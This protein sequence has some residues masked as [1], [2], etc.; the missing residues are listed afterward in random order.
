MPPTET[1]RTWKWRVPFVDWTVIGFGAVALL[2]KS[3]ITTDQSAPWGSPVSKNVVLSVFD[4]EE[5]D[6][7]IVVV[8][9]V[10][11]EV[12]GA[13]VDVV[14]VDVD[15]VEVVDR[16]VDVVGCAKAADTLLPAGTFPVDGDG[17]YVDP[18][19]ETVG[20]S[21]VRVPAVDCIVMLF[22]AVPAK[23]TPAID[24]LHWAP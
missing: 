6:G 16:D 2:L 24:T 12:D 11:E 20:I 3:A 10:D 21:N 13:D 5:F 23:A 9:A 7:R 14:D 1:C 17:A 18:P 15:T 4:A 22:G 8:G 19:T